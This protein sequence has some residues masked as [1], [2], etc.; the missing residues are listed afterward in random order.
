MKQL[1]DKY[2][3]TPLGDSAMRASIRGALFGQVSSEADCEMFMEWMMSKKLSGSERGWGLSVLPDCAGG[4]FSNYFSKVFMPNF[5][6]FH[7]E[8][9]E[10]QFMFTSLIKSTIGIVSTQEELDTFLKFIEGR[11]IKE[12]DKAVAQAKDTAIVNIKVLSE[13]GSGLKSY[14]S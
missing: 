6:K 8:Y 11:G 9:K 3:E 7:G 10:S 4:N 2:D 5:S 13:N 14:F 1:M 12:G